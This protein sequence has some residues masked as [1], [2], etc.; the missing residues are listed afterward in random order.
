M[1][2]G[3]VGVYVSIWCV[4]VCV[5]VCTHFHGVKKRVSTRVPGAGVIVDCVQTKFR[6]PRRATSTL[7]CQVLCLATKDSEDSYIKDGL[8][9]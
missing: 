3:G 9:F 1:C 7:N 8:I 5:H 6:P 4:F 2:M